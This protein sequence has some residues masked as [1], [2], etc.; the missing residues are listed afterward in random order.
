VISTDVFIYFKEY[1][2]TEQSLAYPS[3]KLV[4]TESM[5][6]K[7]DDLNSMQQHIIVVTENRFYFEW[8]RSTGCSLHHQRILNGIVR[9]V[10]R[11]YNSGLCKRTS[12]LM[13]EAA[14]QRGTKREMKILAQASQHKISAHLFLPHNVIHTTA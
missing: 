6:A 11:I 8:I 5:I 2:D 14:K 13:S 10:T 9:G 3:D 1:S 7:V 12:R 4:K